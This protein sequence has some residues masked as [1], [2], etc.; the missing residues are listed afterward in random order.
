MALRIAELTKIV[1]VVAGMAVC[2]R[3]GVV[4]GGK[5]FSKGTLSPNTNL[6]Y[7]P[8]AQT[9]VPTPQVNAL[10]GL[11]RRDYK[12]L[13]DHLI[14]AQCSPATAHE[15]VIGWIEM[16]CHADQAAFL[17]VPQ[18]N[19]VSTERSGMSVP[20]GVRDRVLQ[21]ARQRDQLVVSTTGRELPD[22]LLP[23]LLGFGGVGDLL[24]GYSIEI[25]SAAAAAISAYLDTGSVFSS[26]RHKAPDDYKAQIEARKAFWS[27][28]C[29][30]LPTNQVV[31]IDSLLSPLGDEIRD[32]LRYF[33]ASEEDFVRLYAL[34]SEVEFNHG[35]AFSIGN[36]PNELQAWRNVQEER[37][38]QFT[39]SLSEDR[40]QEFYRASNFAYTAALDA[41]EQFGLDPQIAREV[42][43][44]KESFDQ[45]LNQIRSETADPAQQGE[46]LRSY[47]QASMLHLRQIM[48]DEAYNVYILRG[49]DWLLSAGYP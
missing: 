27:K 28:M 8:I 32:E 35:N 15:I 43:S 4:V 21:A 13:L 25:Q 11:G 2:F 26:K 48:G 34:R 12:V 39:D 7:T 37:N 41:V 9:H 49:G 5:P 19:S 42:L 14:Q 17:K 1:V 22:P 29:A 18:R 6:N 31:K 23:Y 20:S 44:A 46:R 38:R 3:V 36:N 33:T 47:R 30:L 10:S 16:D 24:E 40:R 45:G